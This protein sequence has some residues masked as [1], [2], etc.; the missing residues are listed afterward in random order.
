M[1]AGPAGRRQR[2]AWRRL[3]FVPSC[4]A[5]VRRERLVFATFCLSAFCLLHRHETSIPH[6]SPLS[7]THLPQEQACGLPHH[8][9]LP[10]S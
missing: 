4:V 5:V 9:H 6:A 10:R 3:P 8:G 2:A 7:S 1:P